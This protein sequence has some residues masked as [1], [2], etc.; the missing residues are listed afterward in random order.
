MDASIGLFL[1]HL[2]EGHERFFL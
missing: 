1:T 2:A